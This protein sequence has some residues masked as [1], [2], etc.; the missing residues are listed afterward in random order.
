MWARRASSLVRDKGNE[1]PISSFTSDEGPSPILSSVVL[2]PPA[3]L[4]VN[5][6]RHFP[7][8]ECFAKKSQHFV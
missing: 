7:K 3:L 1:T 2:L 4:Q 5:P 6:V 8:K